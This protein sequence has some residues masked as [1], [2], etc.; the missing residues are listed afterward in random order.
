MKRPLEEAA[1]LFRESEKR[2][3]DDRDKAALYRGLRLLADG[4]RRL[5]KELIEVES[6]VQ[7]GPTRFYQRRT[8]HLSKGIQAVA[9]NPKQGKP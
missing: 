5:E 8:R 4:L 6:D 1:E 7:V 2:A 9:V 3:G